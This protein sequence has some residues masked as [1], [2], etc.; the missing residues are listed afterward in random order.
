MHE[1]TARLIDESIN[2]LWLEEGLSKNTQSA[3]RCDLRL[4]AL[5]W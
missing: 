1:D 4:A 5:D 2:A 3:Y